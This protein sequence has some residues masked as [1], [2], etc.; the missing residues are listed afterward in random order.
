MGDQWRIDSKQPFVDIQLNE[1]GGEK[2]FS[3][4]FRPAASPSTPEKTKTDIIKQG[5]IHSIEFTGH[6][7]KIDGDPGDQTKGQKY[8]VLRHAMNLDYF[9]DEKISEDNRDS[10]LFRKALEGHY[11]EKG[12]VQYM[13]KALEILLELKGIDP[14][15]VEKGKGEF[16]LGLEKALGKSRA[17]ANDFINLCK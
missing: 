1:W 4:A 5:Q 12:E 16:G 11:V 2:Y 6:N 9:G 17:D 7:I 3:M 8:R 15:G 13:V 14:N 10:A